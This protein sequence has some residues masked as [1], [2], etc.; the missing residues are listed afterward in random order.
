MRVDVIDYCSFYSL[1]MQSHS[2]TF[3]YKINLHFCRTHSVFSR[4][5]QYFAKVI[6]FIT[7]LFHSYLKAGFWS[8]IDRMNRNEIFVAINKLNSMY[9]YSEY[10]MT[11]CE[12]K[13]GWI[14]FNNEFRRKPFIWIKTIELGHL[15]QYLVYLMQTTCKVKFI[16]LN[17]ERTNIL[18]NF[19]HYF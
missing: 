8:D 10:R 15:I 7:M 11:T 9:R 2:Q 3:F 6:C 18:A 1:K 19:Y 5:I 17:R 16:S 14:N 4:K 12:E 13:N